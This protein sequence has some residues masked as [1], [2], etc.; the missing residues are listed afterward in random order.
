MRTKISIIGAGQ[1][2]GTA[3]HLLMQKKLEDI[4][5]LDIMEG[6][7]QG[8]ALDLMQ[9]G[10]IENCPAKIIGTND[11]KDISGSQIVFITAG[12][13]RKP[14]MDRLDLL[15]KNASIVEEA[16]KNI[17]TYCPDCI[18]IVMT[19]PVD[20]LTYHA[21]KISGFPPNR[22]I[23]Q[24][25][26]LDTARYIYFISREL[27]ISPETVQA[28]VLGGHGDTMVPLPRLTNINGKPLNSLLSQDK[29]KHI[30]E[31]TRNGGAEIV[32]LL[33]TGSAYYAPAASAVC[34]I[35]SIINDRNQIYPASVYLNG[36][37]GISDV[38]VGVPVALGRTGVS[39]IIK[40]E[41]NQ[42]ELSEL[43]KSAQVYKESIKE[44]R[45]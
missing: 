45:G 8:K 21:L 34:M 30:I 26:V 39:E 38:C 44:L 11:Y 29:I 2:G 10:V 15:K 6:V 14:G 12:L 17:I 32:S 23:G 1:V 24:A 28:V 36:Q 40:L 27:N 41:L 13:A 9:S 31:K 42:E 4:V 22:V 5:L 7:P 18:I 19:N 33:K 37:Y 43:H 3:A 25:G 20:I 35:E 16:I